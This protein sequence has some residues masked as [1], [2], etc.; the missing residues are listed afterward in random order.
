MPMM[1]KEG[2]STDPKQAMAYYKEAALAGSASAQNAMGTFFYQGVQIEKDYVTARKWF[3]AAA[4]RGQ[5]DGMFN[6]AV[7]MMKGEGGEADN[8]KAYAWLTLAR[9]AGHPNAEAVL[10][11]LE[12]RI[13]PAEKA[14]AEALLAPQT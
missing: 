14:A 8:I 10:K 5:V 9:E 12:G 1:P 13:T 4:V 6:L 11:I 7:M 2:V 3:E